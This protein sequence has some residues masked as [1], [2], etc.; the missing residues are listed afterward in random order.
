MAVLFVVAG[1]WNEVNEHCSNEDN[2]T[3]LEIEDGELYDHLSKMEDV[4][5]KIKLGCADDFLHHLCIYGTEVLSKKRIKNYLKLTDILLS[6]EFEQYLD[7]YTSDTSL[8]KN[9]LFF[10]ATSLKACC[11]KALNEKKPIFVIGE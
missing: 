8:N 6:E 1:N 10:F 5:N 7:Y 4:L 11:E 9:D 2:V 3:L